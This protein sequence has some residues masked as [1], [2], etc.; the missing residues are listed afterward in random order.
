MAFL[1]DY[2]IKP[3]N[4]TYE[5]NIINT[6]T[7][8]LLA[9]GGLFLIYK[10]MLRKKVSIDSNFV[11]ALIPYLI[12]AALVRAYVDNNL[13]QKT[14]FSVSPGIY[15]VTAAIVVVGLL[16]NKLRFVGLL[17]AIYI[18]IRY[19]FPQLQNLSYLIF[20]S[21]TMLATV[22][23]SIKIAKKLKQKWFNNKL[24][25]FAYSA[26]LFDAINTSFILYLFGGFE[27]HVLP[28]FIIEKTGTPF[29]FIP[30]KLII[31]IPILYYLNKTKEKEF[32]KLI[33]IAAFALGF[34]QGLR[35]LI[36]VLVI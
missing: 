35:N 13:I 32:A 5:Y 9:F 29:S 1:E 16:L 24:T 28:R 18:P 36:S 6:L 23:L 31:I 4:S 17:A 30:L 8:A 10:L 20:I 22:W 2:F 14:F 3:F 19:G 27:K 11:Y 7:Y 25:I 12:F 26:Q 34:A 33:L 21:A 15:L